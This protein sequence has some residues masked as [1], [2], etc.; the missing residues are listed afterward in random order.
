[1]KLAQRMSRL[2]TETAFDVL[3][4]AKALEAQGR[5]II[6]LEIGEPD[7]DT[8]KNIK[9]ATKKALDEGWTHYVPSQGI[10]DFRDTLANYIA[11]T[12]NIEVTR[13]NVAVTSGAKPIMWYLILM[14]C[15]KGDEVIYPNP[16][17]PIY[18]SVV[19]FVGTTPVP[20]PLIEKRNFRFDLDQFK[21]LVNDKTKLVILNS[22]NNPTGSALEHEDLV[23]IAELAQ[24]YNFVILSDEVYDRM[25]YDKKFESIASFPGLQD[26]TVIL[27]GFSKTYAMTGWRIG[28]GVMKPEWAS[29][30]AKLVTNSDSCTCAFIQ[31]ACIEAVNGD[32]S[33]SNKMM[34]EFKERRN[35][36]IEGLNKI[37]GISCVMP[38]GAFYAFPNVQQV[39]NYKTCKELAD[40][41]L[42][43]AGVACLSGTCFGQYGK[44]YIR[45]SYAQSRKRLQEALERIEAS[46]KEL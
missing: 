22:P 4:K 44:G 27:N 17:F 5:D 1:M 35:L 28:Y 19:N 24:K 21:S 36:F 18:E 45:F 15:E 6:H 10:P 14:L 43:K 3:A 31:R 30:I 40:Y 7:F 38:A 11:K 2:G 8:P 26:R 32:Q 46:L 33:E 37:P 29:L 25:L 41:L 39:K 23:G 13:D 16:G 12:R 20:I 34:Q 9:D 42:N